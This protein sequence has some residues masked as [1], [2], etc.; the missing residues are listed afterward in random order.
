MSS[1]ALTEVAS[2][3]RIFFERGL[4]F[5]HQIKVLAADAA[6]STIVVATTDRASV[7]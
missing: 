7:R 6:L 1:A 3:F 5:R 4:W 2:E